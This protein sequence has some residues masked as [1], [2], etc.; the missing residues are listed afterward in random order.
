MTSVCNLKYHHIIK[1]LIILAVSDLKVE[2]LQEK[3]HLMSEEFK[4][5]LGVWLLAEDA[6]FS[7]KL[8]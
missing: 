2:V 1:T 4:E 3:D 5:S 8:Y 6:E 7:V